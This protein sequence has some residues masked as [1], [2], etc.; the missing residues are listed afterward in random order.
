MDNVPFRAKRDGR[1]CVRELPGTPP[2]DDPAVR[3]VKKRRVM[4]VLNVNSTHAG[5]AF[6]GSVPSGAACW[7]SRSRDH[8]EGKPQLFPPANCLC[9]FNVAYAPSHFSNPDFHRVQA[10]PNVLL[11]AVRQIFQNVP[12]AMAPKSRSLHRTTCPGQRACSARNKTVHTR[13]RT[14]PRA[15]CMSGT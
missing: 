3:P 5:S 8:H 14:N 10:C 1:L 6:A 11:V 2:A 4:C 15:F 9:L 12:G 7:T 13:S